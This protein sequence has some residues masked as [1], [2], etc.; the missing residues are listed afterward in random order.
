MEQFTFSQNLS[1]LEI[2]G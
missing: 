1:F 2:M